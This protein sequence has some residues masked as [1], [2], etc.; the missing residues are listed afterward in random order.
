MVDRP[1]VGAR[2]Q[3]A[4][5]WP[6]RLIREHAWFRLVAF[7]G[8]LVPARL[9]LALWDRGRRA[10]RGRTSPRRRIPTKLVRHRVRRLL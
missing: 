4:E 3:P 2:H 8:G 7:I 5:P 6:I 9:I 1:R 10:G